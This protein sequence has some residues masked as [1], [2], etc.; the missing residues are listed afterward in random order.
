MLKAS[1]R[2]G[3][4]LWDH[5]GHCGTCLRKAFQ[6]SAVAWAFVCVILLLK[7]PD[8]LLPSAIVATVLT[9]L[10]VSHLVVFARKAAAF[11][12]RT[13]STNIVE[14]TVAVASRR[15]VLPLIARTLAFAFLV[16]AAPSQARADGACGGDGCP[17]C[18]RRVLNMGCQRCHSC[19]DD[20]GV[21]NCGGSNC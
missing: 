18:Y 20:N 6:A 4:F 8:V 12:R 3:I 2:V 9:L 21:F 10:W 13:S 7:R 17:T 15:A 14:V 5:L 16:S 11:T 1:R 19:A